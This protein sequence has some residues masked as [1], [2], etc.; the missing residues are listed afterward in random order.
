VTLFTVETVFTLT[1]D[2]VFTLTVDT[3]FTL[4]SEFCPT[5]FA[6]V[7]LC[8]VN[9]ECR[10]APGAAADIFA[11]F[12]AFA[13]FLVAHLTGVMFAF[14]AGELVALCAEETVFTL[15]TEFRL[16]PFAIFP[17]FAVVAEC[18]LAL[19][20]VKRIFALLTQ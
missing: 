11:A 8:A 6:V 1:V 14:K 16:A 20:T 4:T 10:V 2:T 17:V 5:P 7:E 9:A 15:T 12:A 19:G 13:E 18:L 3:V